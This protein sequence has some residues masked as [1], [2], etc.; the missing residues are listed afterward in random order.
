MDYVSSFGEFM[1]KNVTRYKNVVPPEGYNKA[2]ATSYYHVNRS[3]GPGSCIGCTPKNNIQML[4]LPQQQEFMKAIRDYFKDQMAAT[5]GQRVDIAHQLATQ[6][7]NMMNTISDIVKNQL[8]ILRDLVLSPDYRMNEVEEFEQF[9]NDMIKATEYPS[10]WFDEMGYSLEELS[11]VVGFDNAFEIKYQ[12][13]YAPE[14]WYD[15]PGVYYSISQEP[16]GEAAARYL[17]WYKTADKSQLPDDP[18][19]VLELY[20]KQNPGDRQFIPPLQFNDHPTAPVEPPP[21]DKAPVPEKP[22]EPDRFLQAYQDTAHNNYTDNQNLQAL[23]ALTVKNPQTAME[24]Y[25]AKNL[26]LVEDDIAQGHESAKKKL[27]NGGLLDY[28]G[29]AEEMWMDVV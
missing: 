22:K 3:A 11:A 29:T 19:A 17:E 25:N 16:W 24:L 8:Y 27:E 14:L 15:K 9:W 13:F 7:R 5:G 12:V 23:R 4:L 26:D 20:L 18:V 2:Y 1:D 21:P 10:E 28:N 6:G